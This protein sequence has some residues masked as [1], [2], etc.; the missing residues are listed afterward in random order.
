MKG[1]SSSRWH[2]VKYTSRLEPNGVLQNIPTVAYVAVFLVVAEHLYK[3]RRGGGMGGPGGGQNPFNM[4]QMKSAQVQKNLKI[5]FKDV[6]GQGEAKQEIMEFVSFLQVPACACA[7]G[8]GCRFVD[9]YLAP[10][11]ETPPPPSGGGTV[12]C[13]KSIG[14]TRRRR[15]I[16]FRLYWNCCSFSATIVRC[17]APS[18]PSWGG[19]VTS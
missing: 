6:A 14:N 4:T 11:F 12:A 15:K 13:P 18:P 17:N 3:S 19:G 9:C 5:G 7:A 1:I 2:T 16:F 8:D 10:P